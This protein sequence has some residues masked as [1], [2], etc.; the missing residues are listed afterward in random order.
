MKSERKIPLILSGILFSISFMLIVRSPPKIAEWQSSI[1]TF[2]GD[3]VLLVVPVLGF[4][5]GTEF[6]RKDERG[7]A[8][9]LFHL[10]I[11]YTAIG[12][13]VIAAVDITAFAQQGS[14]IITGIIDVILA[15]LGWFGFLLYYD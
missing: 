14:A 11:L 1:S 4:A 15:I 6:L 8:G 13:S 2:F 7:W 10:V 12:Y 9:I 5:A 3:L